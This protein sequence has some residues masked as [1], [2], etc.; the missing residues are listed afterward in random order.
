MQEAVLNIDERWCQVFSCLS[1]Q[2]VLRGGKKKKP[3]LFAISLLP[4]K[5]QKQS[6]TQLNCHFSS[7]LEGRAVNMRWLPFSVEQESSG[8]AVSMLSGSSCICLPTCH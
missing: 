2:G 3:S 8:I 5:L 1:I 7:V 4:D 6:P